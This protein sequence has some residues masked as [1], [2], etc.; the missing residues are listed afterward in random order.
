M[1][2]NKVLFVHSSHYSQDG[3]LVK[4]Q[5]FIDKLTLMNVAELALPLLAAYTPKHI[6]VELVEDYF[7]DLDFNHPAEVIGI[8]AQI[9]QLKRATEIADE[10]RKR[11]KIV[12]MGGF[13]PTM[14]PEAV[15]DHVDA[16]CIGEGDE[17]WPQ[18]LQDIENDCLKKTYKAEKQI[19]LSTMPVPR[20]DLIKRDRFVLYPIQATRGCPFT[21]EYCSIIQFFDKTY[22]YRP[23]DDIIRDIKAANHKYIH[24][25]DDNLMENTKFA[26]ELFGKMKGMNLIWGS[27]V[28]INVAKDQEMLKMAYEAGC[29]YLAV[30][31]ES[32][33]QKNLNNVSKGFNNVDSFAE[34][35]RKIQE[36]GIGVHAL[37]VFGFPE[38]TIETFD[39]T[40]KYLEEHGIPIAEFFIYT[41]YPKTPEGKRI[42][43]EG[44]II[45]T[46]LNHYRETYVV[47]KHP[48]L[49]SEDIVNG[50][51][52][53]MK[54][55]YSL[56]SIFKRVAKGNFKDKGYH[57]ASNLY[58][59]AKVKRGIIPVY[60]GKS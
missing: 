38:D 4:Q 46:D 6:E 55:F 22:R 23:T 1:K 25:T 54:S 29:R 35:F 49:S 56:K 52:R 58:Y 16:L 10:F 9:M 31:V 5:K 26:K 43:D 48:H 53:A 24:F 47:F 45:D 44:K 34:A 18:M 8:S 40:V 13:L 27:Q 17:V 37:I 7:D 50:Y 11:G 3:T 42:L 12:V 51:W 19:K 21:C 39:E 60:F 41:P 20:Y 33:S 28:T 36:V 30:G 2:I 57:L 14:H 32:L 59:W 15:I